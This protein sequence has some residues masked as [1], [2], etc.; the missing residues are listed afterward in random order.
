VDE[1]LQD[2]E[3]SAGTMVIEEYRVYIGGIPEEPKK[4][5]EGFYR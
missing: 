5:L 4:A 2:L 3:G 1:I